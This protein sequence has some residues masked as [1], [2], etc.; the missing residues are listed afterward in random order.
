[1]G[2]G[3]KLRGLIDKNSVLVAAGCYEAVSGKL[4]EQVG[5]GTAYLTGY[6]SAAT[7]LGKPDYG[8]MTMTEMV[9]HAGNVAAAIDIPLIAD[10]DTGYGNP[11]NV[12]R[13]VQEYEK[14]GVA[15]IHIEDQVFPKRCGH[16][17]GK[18]CIPLEEHVMKIKMAVKTREEMLII[19]RTD[20]RAPLGLDEAL[21]RAQAYE[22]AGAD[23]IF[24]DAP[25]S[26][27]E[28]EKIGQT[29]KSPLMLNVTEG[30]KTPILSA[31]EYQ[32]LGFNVIIY[33]VVTLYSATK[34]MRGAL[35]HLKEKGSTAGYLDKM[36]TFTEFNEMI[37]LPEVIEL[38]KKYVMK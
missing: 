35:E 36:N 9:T 14:A 19:A 3:S 16:M 20:A 17:E 15:A 12:M 5:F 25:Q 10:A 33:P 11:L 6:G 18:V 32:Q 28:L 13:T 26:L 2:K 7:V 29:I 1:M 8:F 22:D 23:I 34:A 30:G 37:G 21:R 27:K 38:E 24:V 31:Q 4:V